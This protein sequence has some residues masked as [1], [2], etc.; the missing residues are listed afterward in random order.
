MRLRGINFG[1]CIDASGTRGL[2]NDGYP[3]H[4]IWPFSRWFD[5]TGSTPVRKTA[6]VDWNE[7]NMPMDPEH[8]FAPRELFPR[9]IWVSWR[10]GIALNAVKLSNPGI[11]NL[12]NQGLL[13][14]TN[15]EPFMIS[16]MA[17]GNTREHRMW[18]VRRFVTVLRPA[19]SAYRYR[20]RVALQ[21]NLSCPS[22]SSGSHAPDISEP[23][24]VLATVAELNIPTIAKVN[25]LM[26]PRD[27]KELSQ[28]CD[29]ICCSNTILFGTK[30]EGL[31]HQIP[32]K[33]Y[34]PDG[35]S[36]LTKRGFKEPGGISGEPLR[37]MVIEWHKR[38]RDVGIDTPMILGG[39]ILRPND[40]DEI[41][42]S[43]E[44]RRG[45]D[46]ISI[47][48][49]AMLRPWNIRATIERAHTLLG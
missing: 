20:L 4:H 5:F 44:L 12:L 14:S 17:I 39:G 47:G 32:W 8:R 29:A 37:A 9:C 6:T 28:G 27:V 24:E 2:I 1:P 21:V 45:V 19:L 42:D 31:S 18:E 25:V 15:N 40:V 30:V 41:T 38:I 48:S 7:G 3:F 16:F 13:V 35:V 26:S 10:H 34:F 49:I 43:C 22:V 11:E 33:K 36:P 46:A 23:K